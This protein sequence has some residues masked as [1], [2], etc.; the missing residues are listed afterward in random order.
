MRFEIY[1]FKVVIW[2]T[3]II[4]YVSTSR[5]RP[6][7]YVLL[8]YE[9][10]QVVVLS[11]SRD[12]SNLSFVFGKGVFRLRSWHVLSPRHK[13]YRLFLLLC[14]SWCGLLM[15]LI[16]FACHYDH[17]V[18]EVSQLPFQHLVL[19]HIETHGVELKKI[20]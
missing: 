17:R 15:L 7:C 6:H 18:C 13:I 11:S 3:S 20:F 9:F 8:D 4:G 5:G 2:H 10:S 19:T 1:I 12:I 14:D 16:A